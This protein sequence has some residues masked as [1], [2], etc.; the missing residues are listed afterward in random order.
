[1][2][3]LKNPVFWDEIAPA[4]N[5]SVPR[6]GTHPEIV[7]GTLGD[8]Y[9]LL[10]AALLVLDFISKAFRLRYRLILQAAPIM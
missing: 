10:Y 2:I 3:L 4:T 6:V 9:P 1:M 8:A 5:Q 7:L